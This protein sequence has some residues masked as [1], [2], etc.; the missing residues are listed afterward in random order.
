MD[1]KTAYQ[2]TAHGV[3]KNK[4]DTRQTLAAQHLNESAKELVAS[5][6]FRIVLAKIN[7]IPKYPD[8]TQLIPKEFTVILELDIEKLYLNAKLHNANKS[9]I[10]RMV[11]ND[12]ELVFRQDKLGVQ[13]AMPCTIVTDNR[14]K[15]KPQAVRIAINS[16]Y[17]LQCV[18]AMKQYCG[19]KVH[20]DK[21]EDVLREMKRKT[22]KPLFSSCKLSITDRDKAMM[23]SVGDYTEI[24]MPMFIEWK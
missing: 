12:G 14:K 7:D 1:F 21:N 17:L 5:D 19:V 16:E 13:S 2:V 4:I 22:S 20:V 15:K 3:E 8:Y 11:L 10:V 24:I 9:S 18:T 6:G 23:F